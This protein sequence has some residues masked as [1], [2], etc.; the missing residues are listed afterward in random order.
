[1]RKTYAAVRSAHRGLGVRIGSSALAAATMLVGASAAHATTGIDEVLSLTATWSYSAQAGTAAHAGSGNTSVF[2]VNKTYTA[3]PGGPSLLS[4]VHVDYD[5]MV[6]SGGAFH[7]LQDGQCLGNC[8][9]QLKVLIVD[10]VTN[11]TGAAASGPPLRFADKTG[12]RRPPGPRCRRSR[13]LQFQRLAE[14]R[15]QRPQ[16]DVV[17]CQRLDQHR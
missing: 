9:I 6:A 14:E 17:Q 4:Q 10:K 8:D 2:T 15:G 13:E 11:N 5:A 16:P 12:A 7:F 3:V 1:M